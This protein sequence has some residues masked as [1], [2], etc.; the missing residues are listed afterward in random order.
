MKENSIY[1][2]T[3]PDMQLLDAGPSI[4]ILS[5]DTKFIEE[6]QKIHENMFKTVPVNLYHPAGEVNSK[7]IAWILSVMHFSDNIF[8]DLDTINQLGLIAS[9]MHPSNKVFISKK[10]INKDIVKLFNTM[11]EGYIVYEDLEDYLHIMLSN[12]VSEQELS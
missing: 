9:I 4:T 3:P 1:T 12:I 2:I 5:T 11:K 8:V 10:N 6:V 7:N